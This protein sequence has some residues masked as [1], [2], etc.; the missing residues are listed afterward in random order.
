[1]APSPSGANN[2]FS[3]A[4]KIAGNTGCAN[5]ASVVEIKD[6]LFYQ[7]PTKGIWLL[8]RSLQEYYI[9]ADVE[10]FNGYIVTSAQLSEGYTQVRFSISNGTDLVYDYVAGQWSV[11]TNHSAETMRVSFKI[12]TPSL[13]RVAPLG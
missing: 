8:D 7:D 12:S 2:D 9:G 6:G 1:M 13:V 4:I 5:P 3:E 10:A 11:F